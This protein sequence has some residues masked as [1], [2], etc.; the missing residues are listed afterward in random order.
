MEDILLKFSYRSKGERYYDFPP[1]YDIGM[2]D[3]KDQ[4]L[5]FQGKNDKLD[6]KELHQQI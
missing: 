1:I 2:D 6:V 3:Y 4:N 5:I